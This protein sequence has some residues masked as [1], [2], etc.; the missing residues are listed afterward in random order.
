[1]QHLDRLVRDSA[2]NPLEFVSYGTFGTAITLHQ[3]IIGLT[4]FSVFSQARFPWNPEKPLSRKHNIPDLCIA[5]IGPSAHIRLQ[6]GAELKAAILSMA[7]LPSADSLNSDSDFTSTVSLAKMQATDQVKAAIK[8]NALPNTTIRWILS[9]G[10]YFTIIELGGF[11]EAEL[12]TRG[13]RPN[14][15]GDFEVSQIIADNYLQDLNEPFR[16]KIYRLGTA[17]GAIAMHKYLV[18]GLQLYA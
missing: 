9:I 10:P 6:G 8:N 17:E 14:D 4:E 16:G 12:A 5:R 2:S 7:S 11:S 1:M 18:D 15:S 3:H 13:H